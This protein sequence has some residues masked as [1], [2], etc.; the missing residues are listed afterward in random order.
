MM[1]G[2][3]KVM[4]EKILS[5]KVM[6]TLIPQFEHL[7]VVIQE[8]SPLITMKMKDIIGSLYTHKLRI[9]ERN[10]VQE[11]FQ[12]PWDQTFNKNEGFERH[13]DKKIQ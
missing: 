9:L 11:S 3:G 13:K 12:T 5:E 4:T 10:E 6:M 8:S 1:K 7:I 2:C